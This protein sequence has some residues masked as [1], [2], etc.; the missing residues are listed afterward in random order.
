MIKQ[1][2]CI[3]TK[4]HKKGAKIKVETSPGEDSESNYL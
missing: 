2:Q 1:T 3:P 4:I